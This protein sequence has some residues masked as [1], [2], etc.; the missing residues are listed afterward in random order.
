M[1]YLGWAI[2]CAALGW[3]F[4]E[5]AYTVERLRHQEVERLAEELVRERNPNM[6]DH[7]VINSAFTKTRSGDGESRWVI[8]VNRPGTHDLDEALVLEMSLDGTE[9]LET[10]RPSFMERVR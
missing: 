3:G 5:D 2:I 10:R 4:R 1:V 7:V 6:R 8:L 9:V